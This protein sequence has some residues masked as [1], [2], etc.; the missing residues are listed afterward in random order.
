MKILKFEL[1]S[2][3][4]TFSRPYINS[5]YTS[6]SHIHK[7]ALLGL[8]GSIIGIEKGFKNELRN[9]IPEAYENLKD[10]KVS[11]V[12]RLSKFPSKINTLTETTGMFNDRN[13]FLVQ[14]EELIRP[15]WDIYL[16]SDKLNKC[17]EKIKDY[18]L[19]N[20]AVYIPYLGKNHF[21]ADIREIE[22]LEDQALDISHITSIDSLFISSEIITEATNI[23]RVFIEE[24]LPISLNSK[25][26][27][28]E[29][30]VFRYTNDVVTDIVSKENIKKCNNRILYFI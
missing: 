18:I 16:Y 10:I 5:V 11:I 9:K 15:K 3:G 8:L 21:Q 17:F 23:N 6:Y 27:Q 1:S 24:S 13:T 19:N 14:Y 26:Y 2:I 29:E 4:A 25:T 30:S 28:Y 12:P 20:K 7:V 22:L